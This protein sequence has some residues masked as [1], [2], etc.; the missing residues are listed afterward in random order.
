MAR[1]KDLSSLSAEELN[2]LLEDTS[3]IPSFELMG[4]KE[5]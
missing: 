3:G 4:H 1:Q 5:N 2:A